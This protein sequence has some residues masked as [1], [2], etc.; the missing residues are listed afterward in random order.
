MSLG[1]NQFEFYTH[2]QT[3]PKGLPGLLPPRDPS[4]RWGRAGGN[5]W[6]TQLPK[7]AGA[8]A[9]EDMCSHAMGSTRVTNRFQ[10]AVRS[11]PEDGAEPFP[12]VCTDR[13][14]QLTKGNSKGGHMQDSRSLPSAAVRIRT[15]VQGKSKHFS[16]GSINN[17]LKKC[18]DNQ[19]RIS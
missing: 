5:S 15:M 7:S 8:H 19:G 12:M 11:S 2:S 14:K 17:D 16:D 6:G 18:K 3:F 9:A 10:T 4:R 13:S 1:K